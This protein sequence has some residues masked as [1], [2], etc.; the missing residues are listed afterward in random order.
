ML[1]AHSFFPVYQLFSSTF[2]AALGGVIIFFSFV[3]LLWSA[4]LFAKRKTTIKPYEEASALVV[5]GP[6]RFSRNPMYVGLLTLL[7]GCALALGS[8]SAFIGPVFFFTTVDRYVIPKEEVSLKE[9][10]PAEYET[11]VEQA[12]RWLFRTWT[13]KD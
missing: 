10:F 9:L 6:Y 3:P 12:P 8:L 7:F 4:H 5:E 2:W 13:N 11:Y 1:F